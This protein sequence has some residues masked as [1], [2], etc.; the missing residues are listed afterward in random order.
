MPRLVENKHAFFQYEIL[1]TFEAGLV[2][3]GQEVK[4]VREGRM[5]LKGSFITFFRGEPVL[6]NAHIT[7][8]SHYTGIEKPDPTRSR[9][10]LLHSKEIR[11][12]EEKSQEKGLT[13]V[14]LNVYTKGHLIKIQIGLARGRHLYDKREYK[15]EQDLA[16]EARQTLK[17]REH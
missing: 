11:Y 1:E 4:A 9:R 16:R 17:N 6:T 5:Q 2:L 7:P 8:Y 13:I 14:P 3:S 12:L 15:K 10:I